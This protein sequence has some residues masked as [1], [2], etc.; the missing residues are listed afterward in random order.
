MWLALSCFSSCSVLTLQIR[1]LLLVSVLA[2]FVSVDKAEEI[3]C[4]FKFSSP[5][6]CN[7]VQFSALDKVQF[8]S[9]KRFFHCLRTSRHQWQIILT[10]LPWFFFQFRCCGVSNYTDWFEVY[11]TTRVPDS[12]CLE[13]SENC[14]LHSPGTW[15]KDVSGSPGAQQPPYKGRAG[16][17]LQTDAGDK[18]VMWPWSSLSGKAYVEL[19][20]FTTKEAIHLNTVRIWRLSELLFHVA[21]EYFHWSGVQPS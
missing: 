10:V 16:S 9:N 7:Q 2:T 5:C 19:W 20:L 15:W 4:F 1:P 12:C 8:V 3:L 13:F 21:D 11:N 18:V 6:W 14:G 17:R